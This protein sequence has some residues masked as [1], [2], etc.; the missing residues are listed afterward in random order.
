M[1]VIFHEE[2]G[3]SPKINKNLARFFHA[4]FNLKFKTL[5]KWQEFC[6]FIKSSCIY[7]K[8]KRGEIDENHLI[9]HILRFK[10]IDNFLKKSLFSIREDVEKIKGEIKSEMDN[11]TEIRSRL[12]EKYGSRI[13]I[14]WF[15]GALFNK[16]E[17]KTFIKFRNS[18]IRDFM[19]NNFG[20]VINF[21]G[22]IK[23]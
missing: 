22:E 17:D 19:I 16:S 1:E 12:L 14:S 18:F 11:F 4:A 7:I 15:R 13:Y 5:K 3:I 21:N 6:R 23:I 8:L 10:F 9:H 20:V 2:T